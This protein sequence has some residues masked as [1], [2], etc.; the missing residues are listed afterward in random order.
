MDEVSPDL[1]YAIG[2]VFP[3][4]CDRPRWPVAVGRDARLSSPDLHAALCRGLRDAGCSVLDLGLAATPLVYFSVFHRRLAGCIQVTASH[5][6]AGDNGFKMMCGQR[7]LYGAGIQDL[8]RRLE[9]PLPLAAPSPGAY[10]TAD[11]LP[12]YIE[13]F[14][15]SCRPARRLKVVV[16]AG[17]GP[18]GRMAVPFYRAMGCDV[19]PLYCEPDG[20]FPHHHP[21]PTREENLQDMRRA[22]LRHAADVGIAFDGDGDRIG[23]VDERGVPMACDMLLL[24]LARELL[25]EHPG[26]CI[27]SESKS[28]NRLY[29]GVRQAG[30]RVVVGPTGHARV[31]HRMRQVGALLGG[32][33]TGHIFY[34]DRFFGYDDAIYVGARL[35]QLLGRGKRPL[36]SMLADVP[37]IHN[38]PELRYPCDDAEKFAIEKD[39]QEWFSRQGYRVSTIDGV[40]VSLEDG[41]WGLLRA[42]HTQPV[43]VARF[44]AESEAALRRVR[45]LFEDWLY[46]RLGRKGEGLPDRS[47]RDEE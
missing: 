8:R 7:S 24:L 43:L 11:L 34:A 12:A 15:S 39:A 46:R 22:V 1:A 41:S 30:G 36:S 27:V 13:R 16:D 20:R 37:P 40:R 21:D 47:R 4:L 23:V 31:K 25:R 6:P 3:S 2:R 33:L 10:E 44:E 19:V 18:A 42:S 5:N 9:A 32:E 26:A 17:N 35:L 29:E 38:T 45:D 28:S 14:S